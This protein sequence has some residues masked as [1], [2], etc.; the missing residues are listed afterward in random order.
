MGYR[1]AE[2]DEAPQNYSLLNEKEDDPY[3]VTVFGLNNPLSSNRISKYLT[4][5]F[6]YYINIY[7]NIKSFGLPYN[8]WIDSPKWLLD[9][10][11]RFDDISEEFQRYKK[12]K[13]L[14]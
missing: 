6:Y 14:A 9:L 2:S 8:N 13:N 7:R 5:E 12:V 4:P 3:P 10:I 11:N 1:K